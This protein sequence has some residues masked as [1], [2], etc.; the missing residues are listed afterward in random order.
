M[1]KVNDIVVFFL[2][3]GNMT[4]KK[5]QKLLYY[6]YAWTLALLNECAEDICFRLFNE[7][8]EAWVHGPVVPSVYMEYKRYGWNDI[9]MILENNDDIFSSDVL[10]VLNQVW[11]VYGD[12]S[13]NELEAISHKEEPWI[14]ARKGI[15]PYAT[16]TE[17]LSDEVIFR[18][19]NEQAAS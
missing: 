5:L 6:A 10:D 17:Y 7:K 4:P 14:S 18:Y 15:P 8:I 19:F 13:G 2:S 9:P 3:R 11:E 16:S 1:Y 12:L